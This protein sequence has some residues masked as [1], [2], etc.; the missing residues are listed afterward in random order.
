MR[1]KFLFISFIVTF[2]LAILLVLRLV[3][4]RTSNFSLPHAKT[5]TIKLEKHAVDLTIS[6]QLSTFETHFDKSVFQNYL[7]L[8]GISLDN[9]TTQTHKA[10][11]EDKVHIFVFNY[12]ELQQG[13]SSIYYE[14]DLLNQSFIGYSPLAYDSS[15]HTF[16]ITMY[17]R[18]E[19]LREPSLSAQ[20]AFWTKAILKGIYLGTFFPLSQ[21]ALDT[22]N[23]K[24]VEISV[25]FIV[26]K[27]QLSQSILH[28]LVP[29]AYAT[30]C[31]GSKTC[32][33]Y[34]TFSAYCP[35]STHLACSLFQTPC[36]VEGAQCGS[37]GAYG[38]CTEYPDPP[39]TC[40]YGSTCPGGTACPA[41]APTCDYSSAT[42]ASCQ[43]Y[44]STDA[45]IVHY[46]CSA[47]F[48]CPGLCVSGSCN[49]NGGGGSCSWSAWGT[50]SATCGG[51]TQTRT[52]SCGG[53]DTRSCNT[54]AC[55]A[56]CGN[57]SCESGESCS[58]CASDCGS[59]VNPQY[60]G[61]GSCNNGETSCSC[62]SDCGGS[63]CNANCSTACGQ[64]NGCGGS[65]PNTDNSTPAAITGLAPPDGTAVVPV[66]N[67]VTVSWQS[68]Q[69]ASV[70]E[71]HVF[72]TQAVPPVDPTLD[73]ALPNAHCP[74]NSAGTSYTF[75]AD[76]GVT[77]YSWRVRGINT[78][79]TT[80]NGPWSVIQTFT[81]GGG[82]TGNFYQDDNALAVVN[83]VTG[84]C[85]LTGPTS[86]S[87]PAGSSIQ[88]KWGS[89]QSQSGSISSSTY[90]IDNVGYDPNTQVVFS[91]ASPYTCTCPA[92]CTYS[93]QSVP[94]GG[95]NFFISQNQSAWWQTRNGLVYAGNTTGTAVWSK[96]PLSC[97]SGSSCI[98]ALSTKDAANT[99]NSDSYVISG[100]GAIDSTAD[101]TTSYSYLRED[102]LTGHITGT[103][104]K[105]TKEDYT[106]F[107]Q[108]IYSLGTNP[109]ADTMSGGKPSAAPLNGRAYYVNGDLTTS[110]NW[111]VN[112]G[113]NYVVFVNGNLAVNNQITVA[114]GGFLAFIVKGNITFAATVGQ[115]SPSSVT[116]VADG[117][118]IA[119]QQIIVA[120]TGANDLKFV[121]SGMFIGWGGVQLN[122][123]YVPSSG[124]NTASTSMFIF[125]PD[126]LISAPARM[127]RAYQLWQEANL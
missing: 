79:C 21:D 116:S 75:T 37:P 113:E 24:N 6:P 55:A 110:A 20:G 43:L 94:K 51:G 72:P 85:E 125:R 2:F 120:S 22:F 25:P 61:D 118:Y 52:Y 124:N 7:N 23:K 39:T 45:G 27:K 92:G 91:P 82:F 84:L 96:V 33:N 86:I 89:G 14:E 4:L 87:P 70:Y 77:S 103:T 36:S 65:C 106:F 41:P 15:Q 114:E 100:G 115:A 62:N 60:C 102:G 1:K 58:N 108:Q 66:S 54:Q 57:G 83:P 35:S 121:G 93:G 10:Q 5:E 78:K 63:C 99:A 31:G 126:L 48:N 68:A 13:S 119:D 76:A 9:L 46:D 8:F 73:C 95:I 127:N 50:C 90:N 19:L 29:Q 117:L 112:S 28:L 69:K 81:I 122:R 17:V 111:T 67:Q 34:K 59:C 88:A 38:T 16:T 107:S 109:T 32:G 97:T 53:T 42:T 64:P 44:T 80:V 40:S 11:P 30:T 74:T 26:V 123:H 49:L 71:V 12:N 3:Q 104:L 101:T 105:N 56:V 18:P 47:V 98:R